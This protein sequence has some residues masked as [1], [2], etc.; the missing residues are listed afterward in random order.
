MSD[1][2]N[3]SDFNFETLKR[4]AVNIVFSS[5]LMVKYKSDF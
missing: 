1:P 3:L 2:Q 4:L 5:P